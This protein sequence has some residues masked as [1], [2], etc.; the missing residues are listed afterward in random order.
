MKKVAIVLLSIIMCMQMTFLV[1]ADIMI[2]QKSAPNYDKWMAD[3]IIANAKTS[4]SPYALFEHM[5]KP[6]YMKMAEALL[7]DTP[8]VVLDTTWCVFF[9]SKYRNKIADE[10]K[11][12]YQ[13]I[14]MDFL[15]HGT[16]QDFRKI[17]LEDN[18]LKFQKKLFGK[19]ADA[20]GTYRY[21]L[22]GD[23]PIEKA[24]KV[25]LNIETIGN[26]KEALDNVGD[27]KGTTE[28]LVNGISKYLVLKEAKEN[29]VKLL[30]LSKQFADKN[31]E[32]K[33]AVDDIVFFI[34]QNKGFYVAG[35][36]IQYGIEK[37]LDEAWGLLEKN[38]PLLK[39]IGY[40]VSALDACFDTSNSASNNL[41]LALLYTMDSYL[42][43]AL[44]YSRQEY[45]SNRTEKNART[46]N[47]CFSAYL[48]FQI[49]ASKYAKGWIDDYLE[50]G[51]IRKLW[52]AF[53][54]KN[55]IVNATQLL[56]KCETDIRNRNTLL[57]IINNLAKTYKGTYP[58]TQT[59]GTTTK[60][61]IKLDASSL[62]LW[63]GSVQKIKA[64]TSGTTEKVVWGTSNSKVAT[65]K[66]GEVTGVQSG[67]ATITA[68]AGSLKATCTVTVKKPSITLSKT[69]LTIQLGKSSTLK[70][71]VKG[72]SKTVTWKSSDSG[73]ATVDKNG[74]VTGKKEGTVTITAKAN[75][76][77]AKCKVSVVKPNSTKDVSVAM[78]SAGS[79]HTAIVK[80]DGT[81]WMCGSND[82]GELGDGT[83][84]HRNKPVK[85]MSDVR[86]VSAGM[87]YTAIVKT[88][89]TLWMCGSNI[90]GQLGDGNDGEY[91]NRNKSIDIMSGVKS[92]SAGSDHTAILKTDGTLWMCGNNHSGQLGDG[93]NTNKNKPVR[94]MTGV[95]SVSAGGDHT[96]ILKTDGTLWMCGFNREG[97]IGDSTNTNRNKPVRIMTGVKLVSAGGAYTAILKTDGT[98]WMCGG[99]YYGQLGDGTN[100]NRNKPVRIMAGVKSVSA[101][102]SHTA[103]LKTDGTLWMCGA[104][105][106]GEL[107]DGTYIGKYTPVK[108]M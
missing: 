76:V 7:D 58:L 66:N 3:N 18:M 6:V 100:T 5:S 51:E 108:I 87:D 43:Q 42:H 30:K 92:V 31:R 84:T 23:L 61:S 55:N 26:I 2:S 46:F 104:N 82:S 99:N 33:A 62:T 12:I 103:I 4:D 1:S 20:A 16:S 60:K 57:T 94:I 17:D 78:V 39:E 48:E 96:A 74:K 90:R 105:S 79:D 71:T 21:D 59:T 64:T 77:T 97:Q 81:L 89:N 35:Q 65:V 85:I 106:L 19:I 54:E 32:Y 13:L 44:R 69:S 72:K 70:A 25:M 98:L 15:K 93:T 10:Q 107:G 40:G 24:S 102:F 29:K 75:G 36:T 73:V 91:A 50:N 52:N 41:K 11:Y 88:D 47:E 34:E 8:L 27:I 37:I 28:D 45:S 68:K 56:N 95:K 14:L 80:T 83:S 22:C 38:N 53:F 101:G 86:L 63:P 67:T 9:N 49:F